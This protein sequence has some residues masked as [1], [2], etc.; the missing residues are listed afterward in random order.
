MDPEFVSVQQLIFRSV[1]GR[2]FS[3]VQYSVQENYPT[4]QTLFQEVPFY[5]AK[6]QCMLI[7]YS[8]WSDR[9]MTLVIPVFTSVNELN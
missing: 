9:V 8:D 1:L 5:T 4:C 3:Q 6:S 2:R 7:I